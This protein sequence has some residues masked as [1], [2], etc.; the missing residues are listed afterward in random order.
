[1]CCILI[2]SKMRGRSQGLEREAEVWKSL[3]WQLENP[4]WMEDAS[5][6]C[7]VSCAKLT[8]R[9]PVCLWMHLHSEHRDKQ[10]ELTL[11]F[12]LKCAFE[13]WR[14]N[15]IF[16]R[17]SWADDGIAFQNKLWALECPLE[18][19][20][21]SMKLDG[22]DQ[23]SHTSLSENSQ[24]PRQGTRNVGLWTW[25]RR[26]W[27]HSKEL[28]LN[29]WSGEGLGSGGVLPTPTRNSDHLPGT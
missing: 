1:V 22:R 18:R 21:L 2:E 3:L 20:I 9:Y 16:Q 4:G 12:I 24:G 15:R 25:T 29:W 13:R 23:S 27:F 11:A 5:E 19:L 17:K 26:Q 14:N 7:H 28:Q 6:P 8:W 10:K